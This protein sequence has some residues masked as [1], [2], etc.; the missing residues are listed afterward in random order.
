[1]SKT[2]IIAKYDLRIPDLNKLFDEDLQADYFK[3][4]HQHWN[5]EDY[6]QNYTD[7][8]FSLNNKS[9]LKL[10]L[11]MQPDYKRIGLISEKGLKE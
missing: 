11:N 2:N 6:L 7:Q 8:M 9:Y 4:I 10:P 5:E 1:M 3:K